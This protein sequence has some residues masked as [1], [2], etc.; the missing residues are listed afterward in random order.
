VNIEI[1]N[2]SEE[3]ED[4]K[5]KLNFRTVPMIFIGGKFIGGCSELI[6]LNESGELVKI[7]KE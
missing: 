1:D 7:L 3:F 6:E 2:G 4:L 5:E